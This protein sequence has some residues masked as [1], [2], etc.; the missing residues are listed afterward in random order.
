MDSLQIF[1]FGF[2]FSHL[3]L[4]TPPIPGLGILI[5]NSEEGKECGRFWSGKGGCAP[6]SAKEFYSKTLTPG[7]K[8][9]IT[10]ANYIISE[11]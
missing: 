10:E 5:K 11:M 3:W 6:L 8:Q 1:L 2:R 7:S 9:D 4:L